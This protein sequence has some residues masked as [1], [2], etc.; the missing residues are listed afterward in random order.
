V[1]SRIRKK[2]EPFW[3]RVWVRCWPAKWNGPTR[4]L[5]LPPPPSHKGHEFVTP[6]SVTGSERPCGVSSRPCADSLSFSLS[7]ASFHLFYLDSL[8]LEPEC[9]CI[10]SAARATPGV[11]CSVCI[12]SPFILGQQSSGMW[13]RVVW[14][15]LPR[16][17]PWRPIGLWDVEDPTLSRQSAH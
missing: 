12:M 13:R 10:V 15:N 7:W 11:V 14:W 16:K 3:V 5:L 2:W 4:C 1:G 6:Q 17:R 9:P 8:S